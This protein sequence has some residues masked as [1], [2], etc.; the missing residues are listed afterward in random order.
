MSDNIAFREKIHQEAYPMWV[1]FYEIVAKMQVSN[2]L[3]NDEIANYYHRG[4]NL[5][6][7]LEEFGQIR[8]V[9]GE[10]HYRLFD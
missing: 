7:R 6:C 8:I 4:K 3:T 9:D 2:S 10:P 1:E 5:K